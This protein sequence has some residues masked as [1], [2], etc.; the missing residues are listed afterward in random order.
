MHTIVDSSAQFIF[1]WDVRTLNHK[2]TSMSDYIGNKLSKTHRKIE[3][4]PAKNIMRTSRITDIA[5]ATIKH[6]TQMDKIFQ[7]LRLSIDK[8]ENDIC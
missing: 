2:I 6:I 8:A 1:I 7:Y 5:G 4:R 3:P